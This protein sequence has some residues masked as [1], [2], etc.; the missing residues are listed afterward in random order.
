[1]WRPVLAVLA[2]LLLPLGGLLLTG[3]DVAPYLE[4][5]PLTRYVAHGGFSWVIFICL[6]LFVLVFTMPLIVRVILA[7]GPSERG[8]DHGFP[9]WGWAALLLCLVSWVLAWTRFAW[10]SDFQLYTFT[11]LWLGYIGIVNGLT[12]KRSGRCMLT[13]RPLQLVLLFL[14]SA[15][16]WW[17]FEYMNRF[18]QNWYYVGIEDLSSGRYAL[19]A[20]LS[21]STV[22]PAVLGTAELL[23]TFPRLTGGLRNFARID[24]KGSRRVAWTA[25]IVS[26]AGLFFISIYPDY[27]YPLLWLSPLF[28]IT[29][30][31]HLGGGVTVFTPLG[32][33][34][35]QRLFLLAVSA[36]VCGFFWE[37]WNFYSFAKWIYSVPFVQKFHVFEMPLL[38]YAGYIPF[39]LE[40]GVVADYCI[41]R[42]TG[43]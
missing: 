6:C 32:R 5:P 36:L 7:R 35:W 41:S 20:T 25:V 22:L 4:F 10:F 26:S 12:Y 28:I 19:L 31:Q 29:G 37:M 18:V 16:F 34:N 39:G 38:G 9:G 11:P 40:C 14:A 17:F 33:G 24:C 42:K 2:M 3:E 30:L 8:V 13:E 43:D 23:E 15:V 27:L 1:M 21:F